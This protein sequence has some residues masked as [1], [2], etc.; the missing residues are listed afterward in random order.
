MIDF[1]WFLSTV[2]V[3]LEH[4]RTMSL[5]AHRTRR[6]T[7]VILRSHSVRR[8]G[9]KQFTFSTSPKVLFWP[10]LV[11]MV[12]ETRAFIIVHIVEGSGWHKGQLLKFGRNCK[13]VQITGPPWDKEVIFWSHISCYIGIF[14][15]LTISYLKL[16]I[17]QTWAWHGG[18]GFCFGVPRSVR[19]AP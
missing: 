10:T 12:C 2:D 6:L 7:C 4:S 15:C 18:Y 8:R 11:C 16:N 5:L 9:R 17:C 3:V 13:E 14:I 19:C 1:V